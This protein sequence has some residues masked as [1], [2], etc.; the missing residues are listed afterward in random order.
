MP[1][2]NPR[3]V[4]RRGRSPRS[5]RR[6]GRSGLTHASPH[7]APPSA[8]GHPPLTLGR[9]RPGSSGDA[10]ARP[11][12][13]G[14]PN[15]PPYCACQS[16]RRPIRFGPLSAIFRDR[17]YV[18]HPNRDHLPLGGH[19]SWSLL[20]DSCRI[21]R[22]V[23]SGFFPA[24]VMVPVPRSGP[25]PEGDFC[26]QGLAE[27]AGSPIAPVVVPSPPVDSAIDSPLILGRITSA[28]WGKLSKVP[29]KLSQLGRTGGQVA[30]VQAEG[31]VAG[32]WAVMAVGAVR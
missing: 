17:V 8:Q 22:Y 3:G 26:L 19:C 16:G 13:L 32:Q 10:T 25:S 31:V 7:P 29:A 27:L 24:G 28:A 4:R 12:P 23:G 20:G 5:L 9:Y 18:D 15:W 2:R 14:P 30:S 11:P 6:P 21:D 1:W